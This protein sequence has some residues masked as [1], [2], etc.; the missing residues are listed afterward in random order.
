MSNPICAVGTVATVPKLIQIAPEVT[1]CSF[2]LACNERRYDR[3]RGEWV[4]GDTNWFTVSVF[5]Q[6]AAHAAASFSKGDRVIVHGRLRVRRWEQKEK[7][8][9]GLSVEIDAD[10]LGHDV[11]WGT[12]RFT[13]QQTETSEANATSEATDAA[14]DAATTSE[15]QPSN[16]GFIPVDA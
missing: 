15:T 3:E 9:S 10:A 8:R 14:N 5:R 7:D 12:S 2:R 6:M 1:L 11:R 16:D 4:D 13:K